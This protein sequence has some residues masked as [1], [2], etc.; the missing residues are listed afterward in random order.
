M[1]GKLRLLVIICCLSVTKLVFSQVGEYRNDLSIG[2]NAGYVFSNVYFQ[3]KVGQSLH[4]GITG[5]VTLK[6]VCEKYFKTICAI[7]AEL[8][9]AGIG[10]KE[11]ILNANNSPV[12]NTVTG[13]AE[14]YE[15]TMNYIQ[16]PILAHLGWG[17]EH[18]GLQFFFQA[19]S[20][21]GYCISESTKT[22]FNV[23]ERNEKERVNNTVA[24]DTMA[25][26]HKFDYG[27]AAGIG[28][29]YSHSKIGRMMLEARY[30]YGLGNIYG[31]SKRDYFGRS[32]FGN[33][34]LKFTYLFDIIKTKRK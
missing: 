4:G 6:Y 23:N 14:E 13:K 32:N 18:N 24:Q 12:I 11:N 31:D 29:E 7:Q 27:I 3:P 22:N 5:G 10:W 9:Y 34:V 20:Q 19:G 26:E 1:I 21:L 25:I 15:R 28:M 30:Y 2:I 16:L 8:N 33:I 17:R